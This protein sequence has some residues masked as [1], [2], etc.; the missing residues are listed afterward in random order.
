M[1]LC[2]ILFAEKSKSSTLGKIQIKDLKNSEVY[3]K[4][5]EEVENKIKEKADKMEDGEISDESESDPNKTPSLSPSPNRESG[6]Y[7]DKIKRSRSPKSRLKS[8]SHGKKN[9]L[10]LILKEKEKNKNTSKRDHS[11]TRS[12]SQ[13]R[14]Q[15]HSRSSDRSRKREK[16]RES[17]W[18]RGRRRHSRDGYRG[19]SRSRSKHRKLVIMKQEKY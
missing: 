13:N 6:L 9:D 2:K 10:R 18:D 16:S 12:R 11:H 4:T 14:S 19:R 7:S 8:D 15:R 1:F 17:Y 5:V 3:S